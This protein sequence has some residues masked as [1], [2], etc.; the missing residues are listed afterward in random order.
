MAAQAEP[1]QKPGHTRN[2][3]TAIQLSV[4]NC[5][6]TPGDQTGHTHRP[7]DPCNSFVNVPLHRYTGRPKQVTHTAL[8]IHVIHLSVYHCTGI[9][10]DQTGH[11]HRPLDPCNSF[12]SVPLHRYTGR[13]NRSHT[14]P[15]HRLLSIVSAQLHRYTGRPKQV[16]HTTL[17]P[18]AFVTVRLHV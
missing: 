4:H 3:L 16:T 15:S 17:S 8:S 13:P 1:S 5:T 11:T 6:G 2:P 14:P 12:V 9:P 10:G 18:L 7:L